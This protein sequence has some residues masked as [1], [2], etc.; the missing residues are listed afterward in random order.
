MQEKCKKCNSLDKFKRMFEDGGRRMSADEM[1]EKLGYEK[2]V[3]KPY[4]FFYE[5]KRKIEEN[6][7]PE[8]IYE[9]DYEAISFNL[10]DKTITKTLGDD[11]SPADITMK[12]LQAINQKCIELNWIN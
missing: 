8:E 4:Y 9:T 3:H 2:Y 11:N 10:E 5:K 12:E 6:R 7:E 1:F